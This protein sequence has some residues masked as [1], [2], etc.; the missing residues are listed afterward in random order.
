MRALAGAC[1]HFPSYL[2]S[3][4][5]SLSRCCSVQRRLVVM[6]EGGGRQRS[7]MMSEVAAMFLDNGPNRSLLIRHN[8]VH[9]MTIPE[10]SVEIYVATSRFV[11]SEWV[12]QTDF[13]GDMMFYALRSLAAICIT[14]ENVIAHSSLISLPWTVLWNLCRP[15]TVVKT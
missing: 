6:V 1:L 14:Q 7:R 12:R 4:W 15:M 5:F 10:D 2:S 8:C 9:H 13:F 11:N 3:T